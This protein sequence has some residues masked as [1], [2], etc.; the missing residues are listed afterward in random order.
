MKNCINCNHPIEETS[1]FCPNCGAN[2]GVKVVYVQ[3]NNTNNNNKPVYLIVL[4]T[5]TICGSLFTIARALL[6]E[7]FAAITEDDGIATR[8]IIYIISSCGTIIGAVLMLARKLLGLYIYSVFQVIYIVTL[9]AAIYFY[10]NRFSL[11]PTNGLEEF[12]GVIFFYFG[13]PAIVF[14]VLYWLKDARKHLK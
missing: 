11:K 14:L 2:Q 4:C 12:S 1:H 7:F 8:G 13:L 10:N 9:G 3:N 6:Y 5:L